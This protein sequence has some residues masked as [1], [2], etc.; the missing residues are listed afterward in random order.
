[1]ENKLEFVEIFAGEL[2]Q[3]EMIKEILE[4]NGTL[5][6]LENELMGSIIP[7]QICSGGVAPVKVKVKDSDFVRAKGLIDEFN[8]A[9]F[10]MDEETK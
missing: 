3:A 7:S 6:F 1:M 9:S 10:S 4:D 8:N 5:A 2:W